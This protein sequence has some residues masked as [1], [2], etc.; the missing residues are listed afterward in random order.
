M[1][2]ECLER[3]PR[4]R[5]LAIPAYITARVR[6]TCRDACLDRLLAVS[7]EVGGGETVSG[8]P[9]ACTTHNSTYLVRGPYY[10]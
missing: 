9:G 10:V 8:I 2:R 5:G 4:H 6:R 3:F 7:F 1:H